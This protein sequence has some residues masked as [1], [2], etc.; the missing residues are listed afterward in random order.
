MPLSRVVLAIA[1]GL[2]AAGPADAQSAGKPLRWWFGASLGAGGLRREIAD[3]REDK[4][5][6]YLDLAGGLVVHDQFLLGV[7]AGGW[8]LEA[9][10]PA[11][12]TRGAAV[13]PL[14][15]TARIYPSEKS[16]FHLRFGGGFVNDWNNN[17]DSSQW[18]SGFEVG[19]GYDIRA[20]RHVY[21]TPFTAYFQGRVGNLHLRAITAGA[22]VT[23]R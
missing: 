11:D 10:D 9:T 12:P 1:I 17:V 3:A 13:S 15:L 5:R 20:A 21:I 2:M 4:V 8:L 7:Q 6:F 22:G 18:G 23:F 16:T 19:A 14:F